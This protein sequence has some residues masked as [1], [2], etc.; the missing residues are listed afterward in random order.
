MDSATWTFLL[1]AES[2]TGK[3]WLSDTLPGPRLHLDLEGR[4]KYLPTKKKVFWNV[5]TDPPPVYDG[6][7]ETCIASV[8][9]YEIL[10]MS[11]QWLRSGQHPFKFVTVDSLMEAQKRAKDII[12]PGIG[13]FAQ[14]DWGE[15]L[16]R[17]EK[18]VREI[19][20]LTLVPE[21]NVK[22][23]CFITGTHT[24]ED[25]TKEPMLEG[26]LRD[27]MPYYIDTV[28]YLFKAQVPK[29]DGT[30]ELTRS[31]LVEQQPGFIAGDGTNALV[32]HYGSVIYNP[33]LSE[34][35]GLLNATQE[36]E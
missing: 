4:G 2:K 31:L 32:G 24:R 10:T 18:L 27:L 5:M 36:G 16:R 23:V 8:P 14:A 34:V 35:M 11:Q 28:G 19:R 30:F 15:L 1:H 22:G 33:N 3:S 21:T 17:L 20:D 26:A 7:W 25:G 13:Q 12:V 29:E 9:T 6:T